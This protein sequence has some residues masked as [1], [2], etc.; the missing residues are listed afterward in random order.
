MANTLEAKSEQIVKRAMINIMSGKSVIYSKTDLTI[1]CNK[2]IIRTEA[3]KRLVS[4]G[5]LQFG[6]DFWVE[7]N[8]IKK[9]TEKVPKRLF[10]EGW[11]K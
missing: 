11:I 7:P 6:K 9:I 1:I 10:R 5:L 8:R 3:V 2:T 4:A